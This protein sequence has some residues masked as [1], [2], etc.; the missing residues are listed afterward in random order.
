M[1]VVP[2][3]PEDAKAPAPDPG[4]IN[5]LESLLDRAKRGEVQGYCCATVVDGEWDT[6]RM[7]DDEWGHSLFFAAHQ[8]VKQLADDEVPE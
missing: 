2:I 8:M 7:C 1:A 5:H 4:L 6:W 3:R